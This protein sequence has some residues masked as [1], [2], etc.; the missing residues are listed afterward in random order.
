MVISASNDG[1]VRVLSAQA[2]T[3]DL[4][5][6]EQAARARV[7]RGYTAAERAEYIDG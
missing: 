6:L 7:T 1:F 3:P 5:D 2:A 4:G